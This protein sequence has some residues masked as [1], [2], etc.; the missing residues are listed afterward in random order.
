MR[1]I[2]HLINGGQLAYNRPEA[3]CATIPIALAHQVFANFLEDCQHH[4]PTEKDNK[5][6]ATLRHDMLKQY[7]NEQ[8][9]CSRF[10]RIFEGNTDMSISEAS[11]PGTTSRNDGHFIF[12]NHFL[13]IS[14]GKHEWVRLAADPQLQA[15]MYY[16]KT[17]KQTKVIKVSPM[18][19][20]II[21]YIG[22]CISAILSNPLTEGTTGTLIGFAGAVTT[23]KP[24]FEALTPLFDLA[25]N[26][27]DDLAL[28]PV[29]R[30]L[31][32][33]RAA[34][35]SLKKYYTELNRPQLFR[36]STN[37]RFPSRNYYTDHNDARVEFD[38]QKRLDEDR[39]MFRAL[40]GE[41]EKKLIIKF[42]QKYSKEAHAHCAS[43]GIA[44][45]LYAVEKLGG[46]W[47]MVVMEEMDEDTYTHI[48]EF[49]A[50][51]RAMIEEA[52]SILHQ[53]NFVHG[54]I[55]DVNMMVRRN[56]DPA[57]G[58]RNIK[59]LDFDWAGMEGTVRYPANVNHE[60]IRRPQD[61]RDGLLIT[62]EHDNTMVKFLL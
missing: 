31:G 47:M 46:G 60:D 49:D 32:A 36:P 7:A 14:V 21:Y 34:L 33:A 38:Y 18:P 51:E 3:K 62:K 25:T 12:A 57:C 13:L 23:D 4:E 43:H 55:R 24:Y 22:E 35:D 15:F 52:V 29:A 16:I 54:D 9:R 58:S 19:C 48:H 6:L 61:A 28:K 50:T 8:E 42:T 10:R 5:W 27:H 30:A 40:T 2:T 1:R 20:L 26:Q 45:E 59:L 39:L 17:V 53:G 56:W 44:P 37:L 41:G 11:I